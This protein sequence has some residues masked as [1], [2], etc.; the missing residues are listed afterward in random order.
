[1]LSGSPRLSPK[2]IGHAIVAGAYVFFATALL[3]DIW[4][5]SDNYVGAHLPSIALLPLVTYSIVL[6]PLT[7]VVALRRWPLAPAVLSYLTL[8]YVAVWAGAVGSHQYVTF[9]AENAP[10]PMSEQ[11]VNSLAFW[12]I[13]AALN[14][15]PTAILYGLL[16][17]F[18]D[19]QRERDKPPLRLW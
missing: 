2:Y 7:Y 16:L 12:L 10:I 1:M 9:G 13:F 3:D 8:C 15:P 4:R 5:V 19:R 14:L 18:F 6:A 17:A 11:F